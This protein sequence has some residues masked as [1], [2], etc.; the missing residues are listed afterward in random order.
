ML[1][2]YMKLIKQEGGKKMEEP[3]IIIDVRN[4]P[5]VAERTKKVSTDKV[6]GRIR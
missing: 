1:N 3:S 2:I 6:L 4:M 5:N